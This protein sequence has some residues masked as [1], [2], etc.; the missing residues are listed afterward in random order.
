M[1][2]II[3]ALYTFL[4]EF[5]KARAAAS[6]ARAGRYDDARAVFKAK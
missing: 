3:K 6:L 5:G 4:H 1:K 2:N